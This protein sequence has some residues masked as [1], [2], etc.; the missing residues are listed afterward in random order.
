MPHFSAHSLTLFPELSG[1][2]PLAVEP[3]RNRQRPQLL[4]RQQSPN[5]RTKADDGTR[6]DSSA[7]TDD[8]GTTVEDEDDGGIPV[9]EDEDYDMPV[10]WRD[11]DVIQCGK[12][13]GIKGG[14]SGL[15]SDLQLLNS[16]GRWTIEGIAKAVWGDEFE[17]KK[18][19]IT[20]L[21]DGESVGMDCV[22]R[23]AEVFG[24]DPD[25][26]AFSHIS[27]GPRLGRP[28]TYVRKRDPVGRAERD[29]LRSGRDAEW[30]AAISNLKLPLVPLDDA[31]EA[32]KFAS[33]LFSR[34]VE[35]R[36]EEP[37]R[38]DRAD[39]VLGRAPQAILDLDA[40][41]SRAR[42][43]GRP[44][45]TVRLLSG[46]LQEF[47]EA[48]REQGLRVHV[49]R[50]IGREAAEADY[51]Q[52]PP[53]FERRRAALVVSTSPGMTTL[54]VNLFGDSETPSSFRA[55]QLT[56][57]CAAPNS[58]RDR[59]RDVIASI[60]SDIE[61]CGHWEH[62][63]IPVWPR[64]GNAPLAR[65]LDELAARNAQMA[66]AQVFARLS[67]NDQ[68]GRTPLVGGG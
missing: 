17:A 27:P 63:W 7:E 68:H 12:V 13:I 30:K 26:L 1:L 19:Q 42:E 47:A 66:V 65:V 49:A 10:Q 8:V 24:L 36:L 6:Q 22:R 18:R 45:M 25:D 52:D 50:W 29:K 40:L 59:I 23:L 20:R 43:D 44:K 2:F 56:E 4:T 64:P 33:D 32:D 60:Q 58:D 53:A 28:G 37:W 3:W 55:D 11:P 16:K 67:G 48:L 35:V 38:G 31:A 51:Y 14:V 41:I 15:L 39:R 5:S 57:L 34:A 61:W 62:R 54:S 9:D 46:R 21:N